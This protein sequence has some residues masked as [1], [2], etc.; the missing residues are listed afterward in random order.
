M[1][2][3]L[4]RVAA[5]SAFVSKEADGAADSLF[6]SPL[7]FLP[8]PRPRPPRRLCLG[9]VEDAASTADVLGWLDGVLSVGGLVDIL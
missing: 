2:R 1:P 3:L 7:L 8:R 9:T 4:L 5:A 6:V